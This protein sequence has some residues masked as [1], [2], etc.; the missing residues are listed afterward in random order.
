MIDKI[1]VALDYSETSK[2]VFDSAISLAKST[3]ATLMIAHVLDEPEPVYP[4]IPGYSYYPVLDSYD[5]HLSQQEFADYRKKGLKFLEQRAKQA[6]RLGVNSEFTQLTGNPG[7]GICNLAS[8]WSADL[9]VVGSRGLKGLKEIFLGSVSNYVTHHA[10]CSV[11]IVRNDDT[12]AYEEVQMEDNS[13]QE[14][15]YFN[16]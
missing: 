14:K 2:S 4:V 6:K 16:N 11:L 5:Y 12:T 13:S 1:L 8:N 15:I 3:N 10:S 7:R 9:I